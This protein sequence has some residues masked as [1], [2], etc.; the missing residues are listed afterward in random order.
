MGQKGAPM[1]TTSEVEP[2]KIVE[3]ALVKLEQTSD[4]FTFG[5]VL[6]VA[7]VGAVG[8]LAAY[9]IYYQLEPDY[10]KKLKSGAVDAVKGQVRNFVS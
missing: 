8:S 7:L 3:E 9:Y 10:R 5:R 6:G 1:D 4:P 2:K